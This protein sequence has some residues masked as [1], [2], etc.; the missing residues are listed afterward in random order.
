M[1]RKLLAK[2]VKLLW[3][4]PGFLLWA[5]YPPMGERMDVLFALAPLLWLARRGD[6]KKSAARWFANGLFFWIG[7]LAWMPAI[8]KNGGP[9]PLVVLG[10]GALAAYT[11]LYFAA[12]GWLDAKVWQWVAGDGSR[13]ER[14]ACAYARRLAALLVFEPLLWAGLEIIRSRFGGGFAWNHLGVPMVNAGFG[15]P[16]RL[17]GVYLVSALVILVN[18]TIASIAER[19]FEPMMSARRMP[20]GLMER[21]LAVPRW[22]RSCE[23]FLPLAL[24]WLVFH[25]ASVAQAPKLDGP[26]LG[27]A[28]VQRNFPCVFAKGDVDPIEEYR[29]LLANIAPLRPDVVVLPES[30]LAEIGDA[31]SKRA[32]LFAEW[33]KDETGAESVIA[34]GGRVDAEKRI[35]NTVAVYSDGPVQFY[36]KVHLVPFGEFIPLDKTFPVL[37]KL[38]PVGSCTAGELRTVAAGP[39]SG[40][41]PAVSLGVAI[42]Y[43]DTDSAQ[44]RRLAEM[45]AQALV[46]V[47]NDSWFS[48]SDETVQH[49]WQSVARAIE[50]GLPV[51]RVGNSGVTGF[52]SP[53]GTSSWL[54][55]EGAPLVDR[56]AAMFDRVK[57]PGPSPL[58]TPYVI[59]GDK[60]LM[61]A[62]LL[63]IAAMILIKYLTYH[64][65]RRKLSM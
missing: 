21:P 13:D 35:F 15:A 33:I 37:Q 18:G 44:M 40:G 3:F 20:S 34:G 7:T 59:L 27:F 42:C 9:W 22:V 14:P 29:R 51:I 48:H 43:E 61:S 10:W 55:S 32:K 25:L 12:F 56:S 4:L 53:D 60:P 6:A 65:K 52:A 2:I 8:V 47:T 45:G 38:A 57:L 39:F 19:M 31:A 46:F 11:S 23:T 1:I 28:L 58:R 26:S 54:S 30:A 17:G 41:R 50:T 36:D 24:V 16:A 49:S 63:L 5:S 64:E 62:F